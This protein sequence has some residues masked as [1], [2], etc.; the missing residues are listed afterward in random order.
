MKKAVEGSAAMW[1]WVLHAAFAVSSEP[2]PNLEGFVT[3]KFLLKITC[4]QFPD[5]FHLILRFTIILKS[6][7]LSQT[8]IWILHHWFGSCK[9]SWLFIH[10]YSSW[11]PTPTASWDE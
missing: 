11:R 4:L 9:V 5:E 3:T 10:L 1:G 8:L 2:R 7:L 6:L